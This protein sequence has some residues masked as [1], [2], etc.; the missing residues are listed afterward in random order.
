VAA[1]PPAPGRDVTIAGPLPLPISGSVAISGTPT[2]AV[3]NPLSQPVPVRSVT[4]P[5][6]APYEDTQVFNLGPMS[7]NTTLTLAFA[8]PPAGKRLVVRHVSGG[9]FVPFPSAVS[10]VGLWNAASDNVRPRMFLPG[11]LTTAPSPNVATFFTVNQDVLAYFDAPDTPQMDILFL[12][13]SNTF[14]TTTTKVTMTLT[15]YVV[16]VP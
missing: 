7:F 3:T 15:G 12:F 11:S 1:Q 10:Y 8:T 4:E 16:D 5:G 6:L 2:V 14:P 13:G 9:F